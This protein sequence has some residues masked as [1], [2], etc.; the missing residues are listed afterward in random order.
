VAYA[1]LK[2]LAERINKLLA[3]NAKFDDYTRDHLQETSARIAKV[4]DA[5]LTLKAP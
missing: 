3:G 2:A 1:E 5:R 4:L